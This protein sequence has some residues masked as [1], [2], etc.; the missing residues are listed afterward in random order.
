[1]EALSRRGIQAG[2]GLRAA[3]IPYQVVFR[4]INCDTSDMYCNSPSCAQVD[5]HG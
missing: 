5:F 3:P 1:M 4:S 2:R